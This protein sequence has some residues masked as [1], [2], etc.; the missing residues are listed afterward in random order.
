MNYQNELN[1]EKC[2]NF[3]DLICM[4]IYGEFRKS[5]MEAENF[6]DDN[7]S[8]E[9]YRLKK[10]LEEFSISFFDV[11]KESPKTKQTKET[12]LHIIM[13]IIDDEIVLKSIFE[14]KQIPLNYIVKEKGINRKFLQ[15][16]RRYIIA[17]VIILTGE[18]PILS[19][20]IKD[21]S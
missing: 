3:N 4:E 16:H 19:K 18:Y 2:L 8:F 1:T 10:Q 15:R 5:D 21:V 12:V 11:S 13:C 20:Y 6:I 17:T 14:E 9:L 7:I